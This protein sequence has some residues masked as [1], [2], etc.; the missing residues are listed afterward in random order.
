MQGA[1]GKPAVRQMGIQSCQA[2]GQGLS[3]IVRARQQPAQFGKDGGTCRYP[4]F[5][6]LLLV[7][8]KF[9]R[10]GHWP[11]FRTRGPVDKAVQK[12]LNCLGRGP[13]EGS[14]QAGYV[15]CTF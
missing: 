8:R 1:A 7:W 10:I 13:V 5:S 15:H 3:D 9:R 2:E 12:L 11:T 6:E 14:A 4:R